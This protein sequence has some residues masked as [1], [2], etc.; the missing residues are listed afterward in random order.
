M[1]VIGRVA[2]LI[3]V[4]GTFTAIAMV[5]GTSVPAMRTLV[6]RAAFGSV[7]ATLFAATPVACLVGWALALY[8]WGV[9]YP[10]SAKRRWGVVLI[11]GVFPGSWLYWMGAE[12]RQAPESVSRKVLRAAGWFAPGLAAALVVAH[13]ARQLA[14]DAAQPDA[15]PAHALAAEQTVARNVAQTIDIGPFGEAVVAFDTAN[16]WRF[17]Y[18]SRGSLRFSFGRQGGIG[19]SG[20]AGDAGGGAAGAQGRTAT[21][22]GR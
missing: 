19:A 9:H 17:D 8:H 7:L 20:G 6:D 10:G 2:T 16:G 11:L 4:V 13:F 14:P 12:L 5:L 18:R 21:Q 22:E 15:Q 1:I 3:A